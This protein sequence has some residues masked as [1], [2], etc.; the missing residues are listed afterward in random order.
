MDNEYVIVEDFYN[1]IKLPRANYI[2]S[3][4]NYMS[5]IFP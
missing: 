2:A 1:Q 4:S 3:V 5:C